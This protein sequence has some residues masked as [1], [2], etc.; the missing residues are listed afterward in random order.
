MKSLFAFI[1]GIIMASGVAFAQSSPSNEAAATSTASAAPSAAAKV[2]PPATSASAN[3]NESTGTIVEFVQGQSLVL[4]TGGSEPSHFKLAKNVSYA[5]PRGKT[6]GPGKLKKDRRVRV[7][8]SKQ[9]ND[10]VVDQ[11]T[12]VREKKH[13]DH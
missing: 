2:N 7:H 11:V 6:V 13:A 10:M 9:G 3:A 8:Y 5:N 4:N 12:L 1:G